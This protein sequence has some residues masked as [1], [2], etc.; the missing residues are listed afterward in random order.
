MNLPGKAVRWA[1]AFALAGLAAA[2]AI[3][4]DKYPPNPVTLV[5]LSSPGG[6]TDVFLREV[7]RH[8][9]PIMG[10]TFV[11][12]NTTGGGGAKAM[13]QVAQSPKDGSMFLGTTG[14]LINTTVTSKVQYGSKDMDWVV[15]FFLDPSLVY[16]RAESPFKTLQDLVDYAKANPGKLKYGLATP[17]SQD[18]YAVERLKSLT[19]ASIIAVPFDGGGDLLLSVLNGTLDA[20]SGEPQELMP[21]LVAGKIRILATLTDE[22]VSIFPDV[23]TAKEQGID[24]SVIKFRGLSGPKNL[25][26]EIKAAWADAAKKLLA[27]P[28]FKAWYEKSGLIPAV[29]NAEEYEKF[30]ADFYKTQEGFFRE[31]GVLK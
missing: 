5:T 9:G 31:I 10:T 12:V 21:Q 23:K 24:L 18:R 7:S 17:T 29:M 30:I 16:V 14:T 19:G 11:V 8:L 27:D 22:R 3:A 26:P 4:Q 15:N 13:A 28:A 20:A 6:G 2:P 1:A 25:P